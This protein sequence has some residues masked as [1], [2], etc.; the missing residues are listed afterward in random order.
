MRLCIKWE[1]LIE[2]KPLWCL[3]QTPKLFT[4][5]NI[6]YKKKRSP[7]NEDQNN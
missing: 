4:V 1:F 2:E 7:L 6:N 3:L 5:D